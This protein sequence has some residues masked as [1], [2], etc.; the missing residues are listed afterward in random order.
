M[1]PSP[2]RSAPDPSPPP[3]APLGAARG[4]KAEAARPASALLSGETRGEK[5]AGSVGPGSRTPTARGRR[6]GRERRSPAP[7]S[8]A[9][10]SGTAP[11]GVLR[12]RA[13]E[14]CIGERGGPPRAPRLECGSF[15][16]P[17]RARV[18]SGPPAENWEQRGVSPAGVVAAAPGPAAQISPA[19]GQLR[20]QAAAEPPSLP[21]EAR[22]PARGFPPPGRVLNGPAAGAA[23]VRAAMR[24]MDRDAA[25]LRRAGAGV[26]PPGILLPP[27]RVS[28]AK[29]EP[30]AG[31]VAAT[32]GTR[33]ATGAG[34]VVCLGTG[35]QQISPRRSP[36]ARAT[37][38]NGGGSAMGRESASGPAFVEPGAA[39]APG[40][41]AAA[42][43]PTGSPMESS[44]RRSRPP[45]HGA[46]RT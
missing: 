24:A 13:G 8:P 27:P 15:R 18:E 19:A 28:L 7:A 41:R 17:P 26:T 6:H 25:G 23:G 32:P 39:P 9:H 12:R 21:G 38:S 30:V 2:S 4:P 36:E 29:T 40:G 35:L 44:R 37:A 14:P 33:P 10:R 5:P 16:R 20:T 31:A 42:G 43:S 34:R 46:G 1:P 11:P 45:Q 3:G 22:S